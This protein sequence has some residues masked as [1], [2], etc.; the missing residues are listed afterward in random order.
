MTGLGISPQGNKVNPFIDRYVDSL[1]QSESQQQVTPLKTMSSNK[2]SFQST[3]FTP[4]KSPGDS[5]YSSETSNK[6][7]NTSS[8]IEK[9]NKLSFTSGYN[10]PRKSPSKV[11]S[12]ASFS[13]YKLNATGGSI[14][15]SKYSKEDLKYYEFLCRVAEVKRWIEQLIE[16]DLPSEIELCAGDAL[17]NGVYLAQ[18][19]QKIN[20]D[21]V[22]SIFPA[23]NK[24]QFKHTQNINC[25]FSLVENV[26]V[27]DSFRFESQ[28]L[29]NKKDLPQVFETLHILITIISKKWPGKTPTL[30][31]LS[32]QIDFSDEDI[33]KCKRTWPRIRDFKSLGKSLPNT[34][35]VQSPFKERP[36]GLIKDFNKFERPS[37]GLMES[38]QDSFVTP[39][40]NILHDNDDQDD[41]YKYNAQSAFTTDSTTFKSEPRL[42]SPVFI[43]KNISSPLIDNDSY[44]PT[45]VYLPTPTFKDRDIFEKTPQLSYSPTKNT[46]LSYYSPSITKHISYDTDFYKRRSETRRED[47]EYYRSF[48]YSPSRYSPVRRQ[49][50]TEDD[51]LDH[52]IKLQSQCRGSNT[53]FDIYMQNRL[54]ELFRTEIELIQATCK[55]SLLRKCMHIVPISDEQSEAL[56]QLGA[57]LKANSLR[58]KLDKLRIK[59][60]RNEN[61]NINLQAIIRSYLVRRNTRQSLT[62]I[63]TVEIPLTKLQSLIRGINI[64]NI[65]TDHSYRNDCILLQSRVR[66]TLIR[67]RIRSLKDHL[68]FTSLETL[69]ILQSQI[70][71]CSVRNQII[72]QTNELKK[73]NN[74]IMKLSA[75]IVAN[76]VRKNIHDV[77]FSDDA[78][79]YDL[80]R[81]QG[82]VRG[83]LVRYSLDLVDDVVENN[84]LHHF[85][86][87]IRGYLLRIKLKE[88]SKFYLRNE[89]AVVMIQNKI[90]MFLQRKSFIELTESPAPTLWTVRKYTHLLNDIGTIEDIQNRLEG[91]QASLDAENMKK[92]KLQKLIRQEIDILTVLEKYGIVSNSNC[93]AQNQL[94]IP[95]SKYP[96][97]RK[98]FFLLQVNPVYWIQMYDDYPEFVERN[99]YLSFTTVNQ[100]MGDR[101]KIYFIRLVGEFLQK[102]VLDSS[103]ISRFLSSPEQFWEHLLK[104][105]LRR[106]YS[107]LFSLFLPV[108]EYI[109]SET[110]E[111]ESNPSVI[112]QAVYGVAPPSNVTP[113][114]DSHVKDI[115]IANLRNIWHAIEMI[116]EIFTRKTQFIPIE[117]KYICTKIFGLAADKDS[118]EVDSLRCVSRVLIGTFV[119]EF[120]LEFDYFGFNDPSN[121]QIKN[122]IQTLLSTLLV[123]FEMKRF[124]GYFEPLNQYSDEIRTHIRDIIYSMLIGPQYEQ[125]GDRMIYHDLSSEAPR[126]EI[127]TQKAKEILRMFKDNINHFTEK[128]VLFETLSKSKEDI[129]LSNK[130][131]LLLEL[132]PSVYRFLA[133]DDKMRKM[134]D[135]AK[136]SLVYMT[137]IEEV[138]SNLFDLL[139]SNV[140]PEDETNFANFLN[141]Y[142]MVNEDPV[143]RGLENIN[144]FSLK[145]ATLRRIHELQNANIINSNDN[146]LQNILNDIANTIKNPYYAIDYVSQELDVTHDTLERISKLNQE[147]EVHLREVKRSIES[148]I[149]SLQRS[150]DFIPQSKGT[151]GN[152][153]S[154]VK[155]VGHKDTME[156][157]G[158]KYK[159]TTRQLYEKGVIKNI[160]GERLAEQT[161]KVFGSSG[162]KYPDIVF[163]IS[164]SDGSMFGIQL[165]DKRKGPEK[166]H[167]DTVD[168]FTFDKLLSSQV[169]KD[170][171]VWELLN[172]KV[173]ID[174][175]KLLQLIIETFFR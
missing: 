13:K 118:S 126:L 92:E 103:N 95:D 47:I 131:R 162:P 29:Y 132:D 74:Q 138:D 167:S 55:G 169:G 87:T 170:D 20:P 82:I 3:K 108:L 152:F 37:N 139:V 116:A 12:P 66:S 106:E 23:G 161:V 174:T 130:G 115:F 31:N 80:S 149:K 57:L 68:N 119:G 129:T 102:D 165:L 56:G 41:R 33:R 81:F 11:E 171:K 98:L 175:S 124:E 112:Y 146:K 159:W 94:V 154:A 67:N 96:T 17:R 39:K 100:E 4:L 46:S 34:S 40:K 120:L 84:N 43:S 42:K 69:E 58:Y 7:G 104:E 32:G 18:M 172:S 83:L 1:N 26:G 35:A 64:R 44:R 8:N 164:T 134:Y 127:L 125:E 36:S 155:K 168:S 28:D 114:E 85:Q 22:P 136:R 90:R 93:I 60:F 101:G 16:E 14:D 157:S 27:P 109:T 86:A 144:Y 151:F 19:T 111:F 50:M 10:S 122:K 79:T 89:R 53:R 78:A 150:R 61:D 156:L 88:K 160:S 99:L 75:R 158:L 76:N 135:Q 107:S 52:I 121:G 105:F 62:N 97:L 77:S 113:I 91:C 73:L 173:Q 153:K 5:L 25:F 9:E 141:H 70:R 128:D 38:N 24:L 65:L 117:L 137:Q 145:E 166:R 45:S 15:L 143:I 48:N 63:T 2:L 110:T 54:V 30:C 133:T 147:L 72:F 51:F 140:L 49:K 21:L 163:K 148:T 123:L 71:S 59:C 6:V 142:K